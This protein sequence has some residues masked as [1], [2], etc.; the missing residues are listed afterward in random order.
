MPL[1]SGYSFRS[2][3]IIHAQRELGL[4]PMVLT[5]PKH[6]SSADGVEEIEGL[7]Y[8]R[9]A[10]LAGD[11][12]GKIPFARELKL[13]ARL[14]RRI[15]AVAKQEK[16]DLIHSH[17]PLLNGLP[18]LWVA[19]RLKIPLVYEARAFW[20]DAAV[21]HGTFSEGSF[22]Y[23]VSR[24]LETFLFKNTDRAVT[25]CESMRRELGE[26]GVPVDRVKVVPNGVNVEEFKPLPR[27][28]ALADRLGFNGGP[29][30]G[31]IGSFYRYEGLRF[32]VETF[33]K[34]R[35][36]IPNARLMLVGGGEEEEALKA[37]ADARDGILFT[38]RVPHNEVNDYYSLVDVFVCPRLRMRLTELVTPLK[39]LE[40]M[41]MGKA[42]LASD[43]GGHRELIE[44]GQTGLLFAAE[45]SDE[46]VRQS[47]R[48]AKDPALRA[49]LGEAGRRFVNGERCWGKLAQRY[50]QLY[51]EVLAATGRE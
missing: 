11:S 39:P 16:I 4:Q 35:A 51:D 17:S 43:V 50:I 48:L 8:Y 32:L 34:I 22:R 1:F 28:A 47:V 24:A 33:P 38:G 37:L 13:M 42:V 6:G 40:S 46:L 45:S 7:R 19:R 20:E 10:S 5:S 44:D 15:L 12:I 14:G 27:A 2:R 3:S 9:T 29:I 23:R 36:Q 49:E 31:F 25:I 41:A 18:A 30:F 21:D 26:R